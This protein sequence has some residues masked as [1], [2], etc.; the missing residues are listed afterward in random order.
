M[1][2]QTLRFFIIKNTTHTHIWSHQN[3]LGT[4]KR[5]GEQAA[6]EPLLLLGVLSFLLY[7]AIPA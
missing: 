2:I 5:D 1:L 3:Q 7:V 4:E 6:D